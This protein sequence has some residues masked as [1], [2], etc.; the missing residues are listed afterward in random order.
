MFDNFAH[1]SEEAW[2]HVF[3][4]FKHSS[5]SDVGLVATEGLLLGGLALTGRLAAAKRMAGAADKL[6]PQ[7][8]IDLGNAE[9]LFPPGVSSFSHTLMDYKRNPFT[10]RFAPLKYARATFHQAGAA[11]D[12]ESKPLGEVLNMT[13][14]ADGKYSFY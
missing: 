3:T 8:S 12:V 6:I 5:W 9:H 11:A 4:D 7:F 1:R 13:K 10:G 2:S 14:G